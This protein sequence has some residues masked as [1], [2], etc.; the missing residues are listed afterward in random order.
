MYK[1]EAAYRQLSDEIAGLRLAKK[2]LDELKSK[3][4]SL[5]KALKGSKAVEQLA[6][7]RAQ[8]A[9]DINEGLQK[10]AEAE[11]ESSGA[12]ATQVNLLTKW[13]DEAK[14]LGLSAGELYIN[15]LG[16]F[17]GVATP[18][19]S[20]PSPYNL[21]A[22]MKSNFTKLSSFVRGAIDFGV[23]SLATSL[24]K[25]LIKSGCNH[26]DDLRERKEFENRRNLESRQ[27]A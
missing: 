11:G 21:F 22:W 20:K 8:K 4:E 6:L 18:L 15:A 5:N 13:F 23:L 1:V 9:L 25:T 12:L 3:V 2:D 17:G 19:P 26:V 27:G 24:L 14:T 10:E 16:E 7:E